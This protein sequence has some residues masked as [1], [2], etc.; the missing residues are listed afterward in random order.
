MKEK[1]IL[2]G[3]ETYDVRGPKKM[4]EKLKG[5][6]TLAKKVAEGAVGRA[7]DIVESGRLT[8]RIKKNDVVVYFG[9]GTG[10]VAKEIEKQTGAKVFKFDLADLRTP[11]TKDD[12]FALANARQMPLA[13]NAVDVVC[14]FD[15]LHHTKNQDEILKEALRVLKPGGRCLIMEDTIPE[16]F[17]ET[18]LASV[19]KFLAPKSDDLFNAQPSGVNP[20]GYHSVSDWELIAHDLGFAVDANTTNSWHWGVPDFLGSSRKTRPAQPSYVRPMQAT[21]FEFKK[22]EPNIK[23]PTQK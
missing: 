8:E 15:I 1:S 14:L 17:D 11:D 21:M 23:K 20:H 2:P 12:R 5:N 3:G 6:P 7:E 4:L 9:T 18:M 22:P 16:S 13:D 10:H 19:R